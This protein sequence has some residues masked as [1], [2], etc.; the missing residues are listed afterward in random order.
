M[1]TQ[2]ELVAAAAVISPYRTPTGGNAAVLL[3]TV[4]SALAAI[5]VLVVLLLLSIAQVAEFDLED[6]GLRRSAGHGGMPHL[7]IV[8]SPR[9]RLAKRV[10]RILHTSE[11]FRVAGAIAAAVWVVQAHQPLVSRANLLGAGRGADTE[12][13]IR[14]TTCVCT[15]EH[16]NVKRSA[17]SRPLH[18]AWGLIVLAQKLE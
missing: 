8:S 17:S 3:A 14:I 13:F 9:L 11:R 18:V 15:R 2:R 1:L 12:H 16:A 7:R 5:V 10:V 6:A 4:L